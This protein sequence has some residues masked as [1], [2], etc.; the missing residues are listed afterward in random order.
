MIDRPST[1]GIRTLVVALTVLLIPL[2]ATQIPPLI[3]LPN[4]MARWWLI[5]GG[6]DY[7][8]MSKIFALD[9]G[10]TV[11]NTVPDGLAIITKPFL[12]TIAFAKLM[13][14]LAILSVPLGTILLSRKI[15]GC[16][17]AW[18]ILTCTIGFSFSLLLGL[19]NFEIGLGLAIL[20]VA[21]TY[22]QINKF[23]VKNALQQFMI[24][25]GLILI[26]PFAL[27]FY[28]ALSVGVQIGPSV[29]LVRSHSAR[30]G[31]A[32]KLSLALLPLMACV[33]VIFF[34]QR[35]LGLSGTHEP[36][37]TLGWE[38]LSLTMLIRSA[39]SSLVGYDHVFDLILPLVILLFVWVSAHG[40]TLKFHFGL[41][42]VAVG[43]F[44]LGYVSPFHIGTTTD[45]NSR[46]NLMAVMAFM[47][48][49]LP[50]IGG[51]RQAKVIAV[52]LAGLVLFT[53]VIW[54][55]MVWH[56]QSRALQ[57]LV[58]I[59]RSV[60]PGVNILPVDQT[61]T[62]ADTKN[63]PLGRFLLWQS[64]ARHMPT[65]AI[66]YSHAFVPNIFAERGKQPLKILPPYD[67]LSDVSDGLLPSISDLNPS[68][69][70]L[71]LAA[72]KDQFNY[73]LILNADLEPVKGT[74]PLPNILIPTKDTGFAKLYRIEKPEKPRL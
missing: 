17:T 2:F 59:L 69:S 12:S 25:M 24:G 7:W 64:T 36:L 57:D 34:V 47:S 9:W 20:S 73:V 60:P 30:I 35:I 44:V 66:I 38:A 15:F 31:Y 28:A 74:V 65:L 58:T 10:R 1:I 56:E 71:K 55:G 11:M 40:K 62:T 19:V 70:N 54:Y 67:K 68:S 18:H 29:P 8:P 32:Q 63:H 52:S 6:I 21:L 51:H 23:T 14:G 72:W 46:F 39:F 27:A 49:C 53:R 33:G 48:A 3:D 13:V 43:F 16:F 37:P 42:F 45:L 41:L 22:D 26:H 50:E 61:P 5:Q 4:H